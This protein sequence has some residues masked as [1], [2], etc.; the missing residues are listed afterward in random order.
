MPTGSAGDGA[1]AGPSVKKYIIL[2]VWV[3]VVL[4]LGGAAGYFFWQN[5]GLQEQAGQSAG[6]SAALEQTNAQVASLT[7]E[8]DSLN[9]QVNLGDTERTELL[10]HL[11]F[12][13]APT[14]TA[15]TTDLVVRGTLAKSGNNPYTLTTDRQV[16]LTAKNSSDTDVSSALQPLV[17]NTVE[18]SGTYLPGL[19]E[20][21]VVSVNG[22]P[23]AAPPP[24]P[25][26][27]STPTSTAP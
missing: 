13:V 11:S 27:T 14:E 16:V 5:R 12:F 24:A 21:T 26:S 20:V 10:L 8:R 17:G 23:V 19:R 15:T 9:A 7:N 22:V 2:A 4:V 6:L 3:V 25:A 18:I 1:N